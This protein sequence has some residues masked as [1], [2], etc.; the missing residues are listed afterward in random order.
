ML[1]FHAA[2]LQPAIDAEAMVLPLALRYLDRC[3]EQTDAAAYVGDTSLVQSLW[4]IAREPGLT[5]ELR[6]ASA[7]D[8]RGRH[9]RELA[10]L[11]HSVIARELGLP[12]AHR[13][14]EIAAGP[15]AESRSTLPPTHTPY[16]APAD[17]A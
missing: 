8:A 16:P 17:P 2:L 11:A 9:R 15:P 4:R 6:F 3:G 13:E 14:S 7:V 12:P 5:V 1:H 10:G